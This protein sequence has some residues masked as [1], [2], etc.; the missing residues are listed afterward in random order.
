ML[1]LECLNVGQRQ[2]LLAVDQAANREPPAIAV[3]YRRP[4]VRVDAVEVFDR[5]ELDTRAADGHHARI[6][7]RQH[8]IVRPAPS[9]DASSQLGEHRSGKCRRDG[10][11]AEREQEFPSE[12]YDLSVLRVLS[13]GEL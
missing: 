7:I 8:V 2:R 10:N 13:G 11:S 5:R 9:T 6:S 3:D 12:T 1:R 4:R